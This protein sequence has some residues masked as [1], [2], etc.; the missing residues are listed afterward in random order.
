MTWYNIVRLAKGFV[1]EDLLFIIYNFLRRRNMNINLN[2]EILKI[3]NNKHRRNIF[4]PYLSFYD[5]Y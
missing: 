3:A 4:F 2:I 1:H 5:V